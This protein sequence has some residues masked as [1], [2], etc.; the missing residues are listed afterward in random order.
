M[1]FDYDKA[2]KFVDRLAQKAEREELKGDDYWDEEDTQ[3]EKNEN[4]ED[5]AMIREAVQIGGNLLVDIA[6]SL[7]QIAGGSKISRGRR[8]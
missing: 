4:V 7:N 8:M 5:A 2:R 1:E 6:E 3:Q